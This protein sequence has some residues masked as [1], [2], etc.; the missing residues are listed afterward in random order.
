[1]ETRIETGQDLKNAAREAGQQVTD[2]GR[3]AAGR[4][5]AAMQSAKTNI[6]EKTVAGARATDR[7]IRQHPYESIGIAFG[8][9]V[10]IGVLINR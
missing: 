10:L 4:F 5:G 9:G 6:Q 8:L 7:A 1:M 3:E 2:A